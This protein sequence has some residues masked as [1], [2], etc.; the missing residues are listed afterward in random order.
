MK[1]YIDKTFMINPL[2]E[3]F[4]W[5]K[6]KITYQVK[7]WGKHFRVG[8][9]SIIDSS[10][11]GRY[12]IIG[13]HCVVSSSTLGDFSYINSYSYVLHS[14]IG[15]YC[16]IG[17]NVKVAPGRHPTS[18]FVSTHPITFNNQ[19]NF[20]KN[21]CKE[22]KFKNYQRVTL[23][24]DVWIGAN[25]IIIDGINIATGAIIAANSVVVKDVGAYEIVGGNPAKFIKKRFD[26][27]Q[28]K[29]LLET[30]WWNNDE[31]W[32]QSNISKFWNIE[33]FIEP[34]KM[35]TAEAL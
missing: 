23:G 10:N 34:V 8:Y 33:D 18:V 11:F 31:A 4:K 7:Y 20:L 25:S 29:Y 9:L 30:E 6:C 3:Y 22:Q 12:N 17:P 1:E 21:Y 14:T 19:R 16:S 27:E 2:G 15:R 13:S 24:N 32:V 5:L 35:K 28:I 26:E